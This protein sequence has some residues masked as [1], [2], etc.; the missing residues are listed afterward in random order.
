MLPIVVLEPC[1]SDKFPRQLRSQFDSGGHAARFVSMAMLP[2][3]AMLLSV[4]SKATLHRFS[5]YMLP[6]FVS[7]AMLPSVV[8]KATLHR[9][10]IYAMF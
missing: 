7:K 10:S 8:S 1:C 6:R 4:V 2:R 5:I 3:E 9:F